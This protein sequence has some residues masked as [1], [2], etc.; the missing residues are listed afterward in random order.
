MSKFIHTADL[1]FYDK[2]RYSINNSKL[3][4]IYLNFKSIVKYAINNNINLIVIA[5]DVYEEYN[6]DEKIIKLFSKVIKYG[7]DNNIMFR[8]ILGNHDTN[9]IN[10]SMESLKY[11]TQ[12]NRLKV[13]DKNI[14]SEI[15]NNVNFVFVPYQKN[16]E[17]VISKSK[18]Y[19]KD[20]MSNVLVTHKDVS[21]AI[22][23]KAMSNVPNESKFSYVNLMGWNYV[24]LGDFH[25]NQKI[26]EN[27]WYSGSIT[28]STWAERDENKYFNV[29]NTKTFVVSKIKLKDNNF[30]QADIKY[31]EWD[32]NKLIIKKY[33]NKNVKNSFVLLNIYGKVPIK[34]RINLIKNQFYNGGALDVREKIIS[35]IEY[36]EQYNDKS[37]MAEFNPV[38]FFVNNCKENKVNKK[39]IKYGMNK[40]REAK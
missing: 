22:Y 30:I 33:D 35:D 9:G 18:E 14:T 26:A 38:T 12:N 37:E 39:Y 3:K 28:K 4:R 19:K 29:V 25:Y 15:I 31:E 21:N 27:I 1:H 24:A 8:I 36:N 5:G 20:K 32:F 13:F 34:N 2:N 23:A 6:P 17:D 7:I 16:I 10:H 40:L 11:L